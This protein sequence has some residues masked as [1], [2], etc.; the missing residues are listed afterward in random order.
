MCLY[1]STVKASS[2]CSMSET[3]LRGTDQRSCVANIYL[4]TT[5]KFLHLCIGK[6]H[7]S[8]PKTKTPDRYKQEK[9][10]YDKVRAREK[11][12]YVDIGY[13]LATSLNRQVT[14]RY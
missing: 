4:G 12:I 10:P 6:C 7:I 14:K 9:K 11:M 5:A 13:D 1:S 8:P 3:Y 2:D